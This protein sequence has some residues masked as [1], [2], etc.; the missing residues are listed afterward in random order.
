MKT[1]DLVLSEIKED[2]HQNLSTTS[3]KFKTD[4]WNFFQGFELQTAFELGTHKG[5]TARLLSYLFKK[6]YTVNKLDNEEAI[7][8]NADRTNIAYISNVDL[9]NEYY[10]KHLF[11]VDEPV[12]LFFIDAGHRYEEILIDINRVTS[13][14]CQ[15]ECYLLFDDYGST[16]NPGIKQAVDLAVK[17][18]ILEIV[19]FV[20]H[21]AGHNFGNAVKGGPDRILVDREGVITKIVWH[22]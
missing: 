14:N 17:E 1:I 8:L 4:V 2:K 7:R 9:Y 6:V 13:M 11:S 12:S 5:Q 10:S 22:D 21:D 15:K 3:F 16:I 18:G 20:G 19:Q